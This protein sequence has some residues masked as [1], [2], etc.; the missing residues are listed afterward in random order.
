MFISYI[1]EDLQYCNEIIKKHFKKELV[2]SKKDTKHFKT[3]NKCHLCNKLYTEKDIRVRDHCHTRS[4]YRV[5]PNKICS[6]N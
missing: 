3:A 4:K 5:S 1:L 2:M 6:A